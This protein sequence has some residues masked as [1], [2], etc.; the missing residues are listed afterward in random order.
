MVFLLSYHQKYYKFLK[1]KKI[2]PYQRNATNSYVIA[3]CEIF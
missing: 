3:F 1:L 2:K